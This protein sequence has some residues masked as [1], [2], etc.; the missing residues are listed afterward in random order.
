MPFFKFQNY[1]SR[2]GIDENWQKKKRK[3]IYHNKMKDGGFYGMKH[4]L[5]MLKTD[6][7]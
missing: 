3:I 1:G 4:S 5:M 6:R 7:E 2:A